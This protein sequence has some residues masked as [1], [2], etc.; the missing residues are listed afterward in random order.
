[1]A[2]WPAILPTSQRSAAMILAAEIVHSYT[3]YDF[4]GFIHFVQCVA[5]S[6]HSRQAQYVTCAL[7]AKNGRTF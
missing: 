3:A 6:R 5:I 2:G 7:P 1:M 4:C